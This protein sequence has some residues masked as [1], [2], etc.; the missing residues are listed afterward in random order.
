[1]LKAFSRY[2]FPIHPRRE[3][4]TLVSITGLIIVLFIGVTAVSKLFHAQQDALAA[5]WSARGRA[6]LA[7]GRY[8]EAVNDYGSPI[9][10]EVDRRTST[11][12]GKSGDGPTIRV[13]SSRGS[14]SV[15]KEGSAPSEI[16]APGPAKNEK[17]SKKTG[18]VI[19]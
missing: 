18:E 6:E 15:R 16:P 9:E 3:V 19:L 13:T 7:A 1:M 11:L 5:R 10:K 2:R 14:V 17:D 4:V 8:G 12:R